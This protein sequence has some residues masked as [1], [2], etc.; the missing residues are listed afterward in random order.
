MPY[1]I[2][3]SLLPKSY[4]KILR[5]GS[6][7]ILLSLLS[8]QVKALPQQ[9]EFLV[10]SAMIFKML[11]YTTWPDESRLS[12][13][14][15]AFVGD[16]DQLYDEMQRAAKNIRVKNKPLVVF[17]TDID[18]IDPQI[19][20]VI[21]LDSKHSRQLH[22]IANL[23]RRTGTLILSNQAKDRH[24]LMINFV[25]SN[26]NGLSFE[27]NR[28]NILFEKLTI[29]K[30][31]LLL[32]G[33][34]IDVAELF[35][36][37]EQALQQ[38]KQE[39]FERESKLKQTNDILV[40]EQ[41]EVSKQKALIKSFRNEVTERERALAKRSEQLDELNQN[42][43]QV[44]IQL[45]QKQEELAAKEKRFNEQQSRLRD[46]S[47][48]VA[49][50][51]EQIVENQT[52]LAQQQE[53]LRSL[54]GENNQKQGAIEY[55]QK[56]LKWVYAALIVFTILIMASLWSNTVRKR[57]NKKLAAFQ[58]NMVTLGGIGRDLTASLDLNQVLDK[59]YEDLNQLFDAHVFLVG[60]LDNDNRGID[61]ALAVEQRRRVPPFRI[62]INDHS[63][64]AV[65]CI[66]RCE[67]VIV[68]K[69]KQD[70]QPS[71]PL[72]GQNMN[73]VVYLP[74]I[75]QDKMVGCVSI[76]SPKENAYSN[77]QLDMM[78]LLS[79]YIAIAVSN[80]LCYT[81]L[82]R[83]KRET[84]VQSAQMQ[85]AQN[86][87]AQSE[88]L[89]TLGTLT[90]KVAEK[91]NN[92]AHA[93]NTAAHLM[94]KEIAAIKAF[95]KNLAGGDNAD[96]AVLQAIEDNFGQLTSLCSDAKQSTEQMKSIIDHVRT[97]ANLSCDEQP[98]PLPKLVDSTLA[99]LQTHHSNIS[100]TASGYEALERLHYPSKLGQVFMNLLINAC[101][102]VENRQQ[103]D[104]QL[105]G[106]VSF[107][108]QQM[109]G[110][111][112]IEISDNGVGMSKTTRQKLFDPFYTTA[113]NGT[114]LGLTISN[115]IIEELGGSIKL[116]NCKD[117]GCTMSISLPV[118][119][120]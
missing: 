51:N 41:Q 83:Q 43:Q 30:D 116:G 13:I 63:R 70:S 82:Q 24:E 61:V 85:T 25:S 39:L 32:G 111:L 47:V 10:K 93:I 66:K 20:Q 105:K 90:P 76:Q 34:E 1:Q 49:F 44:N 89:A 67:E 50:L 4:L 19:N 2:S 96:K 102:S 81:Q 22:T 55:Q 62:D 109:N 79:R 5:L 71:K 113:K 15:L 68:N 86:Q 35:R 95:L 75:I 48:K 92:P 77:E 54:S 60:I 45:Q 27:V 46:Q 58:A 7:L 8:P 91:L 56:T 103:Q 29:A 11:Q 74:L 42:I 59:L 106:E 21:Y 114:G 80:A 14:R 88:K 117:N 115:Q 73:T 36:E 120:T 65:Q 17:K 64:P 18:S 108:V 104:S 78:R 100:L 23:T 37:T 69:S 28:S 107:K 33:T 99:L 94:H 97:Y 110:Q 52:V 119:P 40:K 31:L 112:N 101:Q 98:L 72:F 38:I 53:R 87:L 12:A 16:E 84:Q 9:P 57:T 3:V 6:L 118:S 26:R